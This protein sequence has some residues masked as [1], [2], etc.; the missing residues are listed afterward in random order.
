MNLIPLGPSRLVRQARQEAL[1]SHEGPG[2]SLLLN[3]TSELTREIRRVCEAASA[4]Q[5]QEKRLVVRIAATLAGNKSMGMDLEMWI[6]EGLVDS[7]IAM[8]ESLDGFEAN[9][10]GLRE[11]VRAAHGT[12]VKVLAGIDAT[13]RPELTREVNY[14]AAANA[15]AAGAGGVFFATYYPQP[16]RYPYDDAATGRLRFMGYPDLLARQDKKFRLGTSPQPGSEMRLGLRNQLPAPLEPGQRGQE[17]TLE[18]TDDAAD[19]AQKDELWRPELRVFL[20]HLMEDDEIRLVWNGEEVPRSSQRW[21]DW[22]YQLR[23]NPGYAVNGYRI[24]VDLNGRLPRVGTNTLRVDVLKKDAQLIHPITVAEVA[25][26]LQYLPHRNAL[27]PDET[28]ID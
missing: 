23:P 5:G 17:I 2:V 19:K 8:A 15:Y 20:Q 3:S 27:R 14:A 10:S 26:V 11:I 6:R 9:T 25:V 22:I 13:N 7:V 1:M 12:N 28:Y 16:K 21:A 4:A 24:H 18:V